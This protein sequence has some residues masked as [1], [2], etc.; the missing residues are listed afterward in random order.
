VNAQAL[1]VGLLRA[2][3]PVSCSS[4]C[5]WLCRWCHSSTKIPSIIRKHLKQHV[6][7]IHHRLMKCLSSVVNDIAATHSLYTDVSNR[8]MMCRLQTAFLHLYFVTFSF[9]LV[10][11][12]KK[13]KG[14]GMLLWTLSRLMNKFKISLRVSHCATE[15][16][17]YRLVYPARS[18][19]IHL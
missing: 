13:T 17:L 4:W 11:L 10:D 9:R 8:L 19:V 1:G 3:A 16:G 2:C 18:A 5:H 15:N 12:S 7:V 6:S 14:D